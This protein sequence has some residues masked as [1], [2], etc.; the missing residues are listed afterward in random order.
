[1]TRDET[2]NG[3][4]S[5][6]GSRIARRGHNHC[7]MNVSRNASRVRDGFSTCRATVTEVPRCAT[8]Q[9]DSNYLRFEVTGTRGRLP[10]VASPVEDARD[11]RLSA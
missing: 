11:L 8:G 2:S 1:M 10:L 3:L 9:C 4:W 6:V 5:N 7:A